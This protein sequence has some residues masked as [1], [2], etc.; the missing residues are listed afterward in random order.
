MYSFHLVTPIEGRDTSLHVVYPNHEDSSDQLADAFEQLVEGYNRRGPPSRLLFVCP[1]GMET[2]IEQ[3]FNQRPAELHGRLASTSHV[4][5]APYD[6]HGQLIPEQVVHMKPPATP[7]PIRNDFLLDI[8]HNCIERLFDDTKTILYAPHGYVFRKLSGREENIFV[9]AGNM[10]REPGCLAIF[11]H[12]LLGK[13]PSGCRRVYIDSFTILSFALSL[14]SIVTYFRRMERPLQALTI[15]NIHSYEVNPEF[16]IPNQS[17]YLVLISAST[18][19][20]LARKLVDEKQADPMRIVHLLG[21]AAPAAEFRK[22]CLYFRERNASDRQSA[23]RGQANAVIEIATEE[24]LVA[25]GPPRP[26]RITKRHVNQHGANQLH[27]AYYRRA[28]RFN[29]PGHRP[30]GSFSSFSIIPESDD[31][32]PVDD[33][34][35][36]NLVHQLPASVRTLVHIG[37]TISRRVAEWINRAL[38]EQV[39]TI[40]LSE[41]ADLTDAAHRGGSVVVVAHHDPGLDSLREASIALRHMDT[42]HRHYVVCYAFPSS[43]AEHQRRKDDLRMGAQRDQ[44]GWSEFLVLPVGA[45]GLHE[46]LITHRKLFTPDVLEQFRD[47]MG[48]DLTAALLRQNTSSRVPEDGLLLP[49]VCGATLA[50]RDGSVFFTKRPE[51]QIAVY[52]MVTAAMQNAREFAE[53]SDNTSLPSDLRFDSNP[54]VRSVLDPSM[55]AR[56]SDGI[57]QASLL[58]AAQRSDLDYSASDDLSGQFRS[59]AELILINHENDIGDAALE[60]VYA[61]STGKISL[62]ESDHHVLCQRIESTPKLRAFKRLVETKNEIPHA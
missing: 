13:L 4:T 61:L 51:S 34:V 49:R 8:A 25:Q 5:A 55:F 22:S 56:F 35:R 45:A 11:N 15:E 62:R 17:D 37:D 10:L 21:V 50:L 12:L 40:S 31:D 41:I 33:W 57:L 20:G 42:V 52:A 9:R 24:F 28:L 7:W 6:E 46:S 53:P 38:R 26:V 2:S 60:F 18:S 1:S 44:H 16:R 59:T 54:F 23:G 58:R 47:T 36:T 27:M 43:Q 48:D 14:Q 19:G 30:G 32:S 3:V 29:E 39:T